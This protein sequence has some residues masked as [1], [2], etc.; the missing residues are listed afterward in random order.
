M[1]EAL[2]ISNYAIIERLD[3][4]FD[5]GLT[6][7]T[8]E[9]GAGKSVLLGALKLLLGERAASDSLRSGADR[10]SIEAIFRMPEPGVRDWLESNAFL[11]DPG[12]DQIILRRDLLGSGSS[13]GFINGRSATLTQLRELGN[14]LVDLHAQ[15]EHTNLFSPAHQL[16]LLDGY[17][18]YGDSIAQ[19]QH[20]Y[21]SWREV[22][23]RL[24]AL[25]TSADDAERRRDFLAFQVDEID[26]AELVVGE[27]EGLESERRRLANAE[28][29]TLACRGAIDLLYEGDE[30]ANPANSLVTAAARSIAEIVALD[31]SQESLLK[32]AEA[33]RFAVEDLSEKLRDYVASVAADPA[34]LAIVDERLQL[35]RALRRKYGGTVAEILVTRD[36]LARQLQ[37]IENRDEEIAKAR[38]AHETATA[39]LLAAARELSARREEAA[40]SFQKRVER[41]MRELEL[42]KA[43]FLA[44][45]TSSLS[46]T[47]EA[48]QEPDVTAS[49][50]DT[51]EFMVSLNPGEE[52]RPL[53]KVASGGEIARIMLAIKAILAERDNVPTFIFDE[54]DVG[55][56]GQAAARVGDK[57]CSLAE[58][59][60]VFCITHLPQVAARGAHHLFVEK[61]V[62]QGRTHATV[63]PLEGNERAD[64]LARMLSGSNIDETSRQ[65]ARKLLDRT[66]S[67]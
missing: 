58:H 34:R 22:S 12:D 3:V 17:G 13:R 26:K 40:R 36:D 24:A 45:L 29:L 16:R 67:N 35:I 43:V 47:C 60:Q 27:D 37:D 11:D 66:S 25:S 8:G 1:I 59:H 19:Y 33:L 51:I 56:S 50:A 9:T 48:S 20:A 23:A 2:R 46:G 4:E 32:D 57:L 61:V 49:G 55:I 28:R 21:Q 7:I 63:R 31:P 5:S 15:H 6:T 64:A 38:K 42:P 10:A 18:S 44:R 62:S 39:A 30:T 53:R 14:Q 52:T 65:Y 54:I 41:E